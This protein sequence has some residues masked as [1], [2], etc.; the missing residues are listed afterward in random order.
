MGVGGW[1]GGRGGGGGG[2][3]AGAAAGGVGGG[4]TSQGMWPARCR[5]QAGRRNR[6]SA[7]L[8]IRRIPIRTV[9]K[10][11]AA[12]QS[13]WCA[14]AVAAAWQRR[15]HRCFAAAEPQLSGGACFAAPDPL[16]ATHVTLQRLPYKAELAALVWPDEA[17]AQRAACPR[18]HTT[19]PPVNVASAP[20][21]CPP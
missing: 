20:S 11:G 6:R 19:E 15:R 16:K 17:A 2:A 8:A 4:A 9:V 12:R 13:P 10:R 5:T 18:R 7:L 1:G 3:G 14:P 21:P